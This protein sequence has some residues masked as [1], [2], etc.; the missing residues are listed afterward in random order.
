M[1]SEDFEH[2]RDYD[3]K[4]RIAEE[5]KNK[6]F[7]SINFLFQGKNEIILLALYNKG[8]ERVRSYDLKK[9]GFDWQILVSYDSRVDN[10]ILGQ[11]SYHS[12]NHFVG[13]DLMLED[14]RS[15]FFKIIK[16]NN[17]EKR[18]ELLNKIRNK[19]YEINGFLNEA[20]MWASGEGGGSDMEMS[21]YYRDKA[22]KAEMELH[23]L[24]SEILEIE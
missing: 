21:I 8:I 19:K 16:T 20:Y 17:S 11:I 7:T 6:I 3:E 9:C 13:F 12:E 22:S 14:T 18:V 2:F 10:P 5:H 4:F 23:I 24:K 15:D 1:N